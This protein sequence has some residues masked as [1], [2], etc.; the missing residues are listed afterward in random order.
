MKEIKKNLKKQ[1]SS[2]RELFGPGMVIYWFGIVDHAPIEDGIIIETNE[3]IDD[4]WDF[5]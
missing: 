2:Y 1:L 5:E 3:V 4:H